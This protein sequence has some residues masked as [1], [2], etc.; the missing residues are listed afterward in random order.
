MGKVSAKGNNQGSPKSLKDVSGWA[1][2]DYKTKHS[3]IMWIFEG[4]FA[5]IN[6][7]LVGGKYLTEFALRLGANAFHIGLIS[8]LPFILQPATI[9]SSYLCNQIG[10]RK[11]VTIAGVFLARCIWFTVIP[12][13]I[14]KKY[15]G[16]HTIIVFTIF[17]AL[18]ALGGALS[19]N[20]WILWMKDVVPEKIRGRYFG[21]RTAVLSFLTIVI[22]YIA[23]MSRDNFKEL[24]KTDLFYLIF[25]TIAFLAAII[26]IRLIKGRY[27]PKIQPSESPSPVSIIREF[28]K[29]KKFLPLSRAM[30]FWNFGVGISSPFFSVH[31]L[32][33]LD[34]NFVQIWVYTLLALIFGFAFN[35]I[36]GYLMDKAGC[37]PVILFNAMLISAIPLL[38]LI[39]T[40]KNIVPVYI[41]AVI[42]GI[43]WTG[44]NLA[45]FN[46][47]MSFI[48]KK[49]DSFLLSLFL[50][51]S[52]LSFGL[53]SIAG[54]IIAYHLRFWV[55]TVFGHVLINYHILFF[56]S[57]IIRGIGAFL[58]KDIQDSKQHGVIYLFQIMGIE[59]QKRY[60]VTKEYIYMAKNK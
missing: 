55:V 1:E 58:L 32:T 39:A 24:N 14:F 38:W 20:A 26:N 46:V 34:M 60:F 13:I 15:L 7:I 22:D 6:V 43:C 37:K 29:N 42:T 45:M 51:I 41:D 57:A 2:L 10:S 28:F 59:L 11:K 40:K 17:Y 56:A 52:G 21:F 31:M 25:F 54:G 18:M 19:G 49:D 30:I 48:S 23:S 16:D 36:W 47:P 9:I 33:I 8:A 44:F 4:I 35:F 3:L 27:E 50:A 12:L 5:Q 53:G